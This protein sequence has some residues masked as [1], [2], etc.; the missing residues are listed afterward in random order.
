MLNIIRK[1]SMFFQILLLKR[2]F[3]FSGTEKLHS[4]F[5]NY[6]MAK[7]EIQKVPIKSMRANKKYQA[8]KK[9]LEIIW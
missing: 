4:P 7:A 1:F 9:I 3:S 8:A 5:Q 6:N 2:A